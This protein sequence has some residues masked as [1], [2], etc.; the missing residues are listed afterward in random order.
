MSLREW[1]NTEVDPIIKPLVA[2]ALVEQPEDFE[3]WLLNQLKGSTS[4]GSASSKSA[5]KRVV[6][7]AD[8][9]EESGGEDGTGK[10]KLGPDGEEYID[11]ESSSD[12]EEVKPYSGP[13]VLK[14]QKINLNVL[15]CHGIVQQPIQCKMTVRPLRSVNANMSD[16]AYIECTVPAWNGWIRKLVLV[17]KDL[18]IMLGE[19]PVYNEDLA[20]EILTKIQLVKFCGGSKLV[21]PATSDTLLY[22]KEKKM[23]DK[24]KLLSVVKYSSN[25]FKITTAEPDY[26]EDEK[27]EDEDDDEEEEDENDE[28]NKKGSDADNSDFSSDES[29]SEDEVQARE[30]LLITE[31]EAREALRLEGWMSMEELAENMLDRMVVSQNDEL[32]MRPL[33]EPY[34]GPSVLLEKK[35]TVSLLDEHGSIINMIQSK[36]TVKPLRAISLS[37]GNG[38][39]ISIEDPE[40]TQDDLCML[41]LTETELRAME[42]DYFDEYE[43]QQ[44]MTSE[45]G[46]L[47]AERIQV[48]KHRGMHHLVIPP[49]KPK[50]LAHKERSFGP[51]NKKKLEVF[52]WTSELVKIKSTQ[53]YPEGWTAEDGPIEEVDS[54]ESEDEIEARNTLFVTKGEAKRALLEQNRVE[55]ED[56]A[57]TVLDR[58]VM[59]DGT[60]ALKYLPLPYTGPELLFK[61]KVDVIMLNEANE[62]ESIIHTLVTVKPL[63]AI[64][65]SLGDGVQISVQDPE[66]AKEFGN[67][68][69]DLGVLTLNKD[70]IQRLMPQYYVNPADRPR[71]SSKKIEFWTDAV[72]ADIAKTIRLVKLKVGIKLVLPP[73]VAQLLYFKERKF[74]PDDQRLISVYK[75]SPE[76]LTLTTAKLY[77]QIDDDDY[78]EENDEYDEPQVVQTMLISKAEAKYATNADSKASLEN[79]AQMVVGRLTQ[80]QGE[81]KLKYMPKPYTGPQVL[82]VTK[83][84]VSVFDYQ[85]DEEDEIY[86]TVTVKPLRAVSATLGDG[87]QISVMDPEE[88][89]EQDP[90]DLGMLT[91]GIAELKELLPDAIAPDASVDDIMTEETADLVIERIHFIT[92]KNGRVKKLVL[93]PSMPKILT[94]G[95][96]Q[97]ASD[98]MKIKL[99][100]Q[101]MFVTKVEAKHVMEIK[102]KATLGEIARRLKKECEIDDD[103]LCLK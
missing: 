82:K 22:F 32:T 83:T 53:L 85:N 73:K 17:E 23:G 90:E 99:S 76:V 42:P 48:I 21:L 3:L 46:E 100:G 28:E 30:V 44:L 79:L 1:L 84:K 66:D 69:E 4:G 71:I 88:E 47:L 12:E 36:G 9:D 101:E 56:I 29:E 33:P 89:G 74:G 38:V 92:W 80:V 64:S 49:K 70:E 96:W 26:D 31:K 13:S 91:F 60:L 15:D 95:V 5:A 20:D 52:R 27:N 45:L 16:G 55:I 6:S 39:Q 35:M 18:T 24:S 40:F 68:A 102:E 61:E 8:S 43:G 37:L 97:Y 87:I 10:I 77:P 86:T 93:P 54:E 62:Q 19:D 63:R 94:T 65:A 34:T 57:N 14:T 58:I 75:L 7:Y 59:S 50:L 81:M 67:E 41:V 25:V 103:K 2:R 11:S 78:D 72:G 98:L 51:D